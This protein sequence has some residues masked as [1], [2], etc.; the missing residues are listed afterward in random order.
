MEYFVG[1]SLDQVSISFTFLYREAKEITL[2]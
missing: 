1:F 2:R